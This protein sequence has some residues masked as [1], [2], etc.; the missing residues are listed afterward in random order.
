[1]TTRTLVSCLACATVYTARV[2]D[3]G[4]FIL[5]T[6]DGN[7]ACGNEAFKEVTDRSVA[8]EPVTQSSGP[9]DAPSQEIDA[10][11]AVSHRSEEEFV[12]MSADNETELAEFPQTEDLSSERLERLFREHCDMFRDRTVEGTSDAVIRRLAMAKLRWHLSENA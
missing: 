11:P 4:S 10:R 3:D 12:T 8:P 1:M 2:R 7:C 5:P 9:W 6:T